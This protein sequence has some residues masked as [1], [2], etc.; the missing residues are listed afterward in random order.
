MRRQNKIPVW[1][2]LNLLDFLKMKDE[3]KFSGLDWSGNQ[4]KFK[5]SSNLKNSNGL[6][7]LLPV[8][9]GDK[10]IIPDYR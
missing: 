10:K 5:L 7:F 6:T 1:T 4:L 9:H 3:A 8:N 2:E